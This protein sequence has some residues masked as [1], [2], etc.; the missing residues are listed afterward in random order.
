MVR[1]KGIAIN[2]YTLPKSK[3]LSKSEPKEPKER[4]GE[5]R[6]QEVVHCPSR[7]EKMIT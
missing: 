2:W 3:N 5:K 6:G 7:R 1:P 4:K